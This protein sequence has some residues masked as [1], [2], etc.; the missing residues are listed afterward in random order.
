MELCSR[1]QLWKNS[2]QLFPSLWSLCKVPQ[3]LM[4][5]QTLQ[6]A[7]SRQASTSP[8]IHP[9]EADLT[10]YGNCL[11]QLIF[12]LIMINL[13]DEFHLSFLFTNC[14]QTDCKN[15]IVIW[16][17]ILEKQ[18]ARRPEAS[19]GDFIC[20]P[21][22][23]TKLTVWEG[24]LE[25]AQRWNKTRQWDKT[26]GLHAEGYLEATNVPCAHKD[27]SAERNRISSWL[28]LNV[29]WMHAIFIHPWSEL[30]I[31]TYS[32]LSIQTSVA[33]SFRKELIKAQ[34][35]VKRCVS[36]FPL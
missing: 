28:S 14:F 27:P 3:D 10:F 11:H 13:F 21:T 20:S 7:V 31:M 36:F 22:V 23:E 35:Q 24:N 1:L 12:F 15:T 34:F 6:M 17:L 4:Q 9:A 30:W 19:K 5:R 18:N 32:L 2:G 26:R 33:L 25:Q 29:C 16:R 8:K